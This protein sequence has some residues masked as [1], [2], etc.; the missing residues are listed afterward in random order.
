MDTFEEINN[1]IDSD[2]EPQRVMRK[3]EFKAPVVK[4]GPN[5]ERAY[6]VDMTAKKLNKPF[7]QV[8]GLTRD[9]PIR[10]LQEMYAICDQSDNFSRLWFGL[11]KK[12]LMH[13][14]E[15]QSMV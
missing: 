1:Q 5:S 3:I 8:L 2:Y 4:K 9:W 12:S 14:Q 13:K 10:W 7:V 11:R 6:W 15:D